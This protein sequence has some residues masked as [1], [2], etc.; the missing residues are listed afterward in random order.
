MFYIVISSELIYIYI[1]SDRTLPVGKYVK[2]VLFLYDDACLQTS[3][4]R[5]CAEP[6]RYDSHPDGMKHPPPRA[7]EAPTNSLICFAI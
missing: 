2:Y 4:F 3:G 7:W 1:Y 5:T 6:V